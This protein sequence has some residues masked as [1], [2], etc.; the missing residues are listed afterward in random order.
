MGL[1]F[2]IVVELSHRVVHPVEA[3]VLV[4]FIVLTIGEVV[5]IAVAR[6]GIDE[7]GHDLERVGD[8]ESVSVREHC[9]FRMVDVV[10]VFRQL[11][12]HHLGAILAA[13]GKGDGVFIGG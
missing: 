10:R 8:V 11:H 6:L 13:V 2:G 5:T 1:G 4:V 7:E 9:V 12:C 3:G